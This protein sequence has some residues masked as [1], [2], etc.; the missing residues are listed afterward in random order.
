MEISL[1]KI[2]LV[3]DRTGVSYKEAKEALIKAEGSVVDA[4]IMLEDEIDI[5]PK[6]KAG[7]TALQIVEK[8][9]SLIKKGNISKI[10]VKKNSEVILNVPVNLGIIGAICIPWTMIITTIV[11]LG[12]KCSIELVKD[13]GEVINISEKASTTFGDVK[14]GCSIIADEVK[15]KG[16]GAYNQVKDKAASVINKTRFGRDEE[17]YDFED[18]DYFN[19]D[20]DYDFDEEDEDIEVIID[21][22]DDMMFEDIEDIGDIADEIIEF[23]EEVAAEFAEETEAV[24]EEVM[25]GIDEAGD[26]FEEAIKGYEAKKEK[27]D[28]F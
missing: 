22:E 14:E 2:E 16:E 7:D 1:K 21:L 26:K 17:Y 4:I 11:A 20:D 19:F 13:N 12:A 5:A 24:V 27:F 6:T 3:K 10:M 28:M 18:D 8:I 15:I 23:A 9:K 25:N